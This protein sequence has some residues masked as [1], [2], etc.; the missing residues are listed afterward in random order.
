MNREIPIPKNK[1]LII[2]MLGEYSE[3]EK[4]EFYES[5][6]VLKKDNR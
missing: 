4:Q 1:T 6:K 5:E 2:K 3:E